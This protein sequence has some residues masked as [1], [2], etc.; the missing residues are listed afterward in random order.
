MTTNGVNFQKAV[1]YCIKNGATV[2]ES[3]AKFGVDYK[4]LS[5][6][7][8]E[9]MNPNGGGAPEDKLEISNHVAKQ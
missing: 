6:Y 3:A 2:S 9:A 1:D 7:L 8:S 4:E 5:R